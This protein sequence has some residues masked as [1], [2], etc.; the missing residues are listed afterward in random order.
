[1][2]GKAKKGASSKAQTDQC[3]ECGSCGSKQ[4]SGDV[5]AALLQLVSKVTEL[6]E[7]NNEL[8]KEVAELKN[9]RTH[10]LS[11]VEALENKSGDWSPARSHLTASTSDISAM[12]CTVADEL[13]ERKEKELNVVIYG[14]PELPRED[15]NDPTEEKEQDNVSKFLNENL[16]VENPDLSRTFRMGRRNPNKPR[17]VKVMFNNAAPRKSTLDN[18]KSLGRLPEHHEYR[19]VFIR[20]DWT[21]AQRDQD[22]IRRQSMRRR[23][24]R[25]HTPE[26]LDRDENNMSQNHTPENLD[27]DENNMSPEHPSHSRP[28]RSHRNQQS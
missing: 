23:P 20:P 11:R 8:S 3:E 5:T 21:K 1:M 6:L 18:A 22:Y 13:A 15:D 9:S 10:L 19:K 14:L 12:T 2:T 17:P 4:P 24:A 16:N 25:N 28:R 27:R 7:R 26:N